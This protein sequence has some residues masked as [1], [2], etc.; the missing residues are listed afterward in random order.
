[1]HFKL[2]RDLSAQS[3]YNSMQFN[4][5]Y[6]LSVHRALVIFMHQQADEGISGMPPPLL[7]LLLLLL[8]VS[9]DDG[10]WRRIGLVEQPQINARPTAATPVNFA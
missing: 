6:R 4:S 3:V 9:R 5:G 2:G 10:R 8:V 7:L 1:M